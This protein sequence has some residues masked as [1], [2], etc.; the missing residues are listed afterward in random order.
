MS[1]DISINVSNRIPNG[2][3]IISKPSYL[4]TLDQ[5]L[6]KNKGIKYFITLDKPELLNGFIQAK[7]LFIGDDMSESDIII[8]FNTILTSTKKDL[9]L[10]MLFPLH[11]ICSMRSL[12]F[13]A[14]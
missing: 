8:N 11:K 4:I 5:N 2:S 9:I 13:K 14:K 1:N 12:A 10:E 7:G 3:K 6:G